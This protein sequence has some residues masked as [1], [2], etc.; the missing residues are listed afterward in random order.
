MLTKIER[1]QDFQRLKRI[2]FHVFIIGWMFVWFIGLSC[3]AVLNVFG[4]AYWS[5]P[6]GLGLLVLR[7]VFF[8]LLALDVWSILNHRTLADYSNF[9]H[10]KTK[11]LGARFACRVVFMGLTML[12]F[13][14]LYAGYITQGDS[15]TFFNIVFPL[16]MLAY[17]FFQQTT[18][19]LLLFDIIRKYVSRQKAM[20]LTALVFGLT[21]LLAIVNVEFIWALLLTLLSGSSMLGWLFIR[22][23]TASLSVPILIHYAFWVIV[24]SQ[25]PLF[26]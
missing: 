17:V 21:H 14:L 12:Y 13:I 24:G 2:N 5:S 23:K 4:L 11:S 1:A 8:G 3:E 15:P 18:I 16:R 22:K 25:L 19:T 10:Y 26:D 9:F 20:F 6:I 7:D